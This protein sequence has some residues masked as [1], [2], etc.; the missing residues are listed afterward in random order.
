MGCLQ[1]T[2]LEDLY[3][4]YRPKKRTRATVAREKGLDALAERIMAANVADAADL[5]LEAEGAAYVSTE[6]G[7]A[8]AEEALAGASDI[9]AEG[10]ADRADYRSHLRE[11]ILQHGVFASTVKPEYPEGSTKFEMYRSF[12]IR[13]KEIHPHNMLALLRGEKEGILTIDTGV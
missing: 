5:D 3:L 7:V 13:A 2:E 9:I 10:V 12:K 4:P 6:K 1:K 8:T 11:H